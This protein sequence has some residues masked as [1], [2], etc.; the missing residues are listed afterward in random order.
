M[1]G[2]NACP[3][4]G[5]WP[6][7]GAGPGAAG[8]SPA[9]GVSSTSGRATSNCRPRRCQ[10]LPPVTR[11]GGQDQHLRHPDGRRR[12]AGS[13]SAASVAACGGAGQVGADVLEF[14]QL[15][16]Q[17][18]ANPVQRGAGLVEFHLGG[19]VGMLLDPQPVLQH[20][21]LG[22]PD[23]QAAFQ[24]SL[25]LGGD[26]RRNPLD[27]RAQGGH[28]LL[29]SIQQALD[30]V[31]EIQHPGQGSLPDAGASGG[32]TRKAPRSPARPGRVLKWTAWRDPEVCPQ[33][34]PARRAAA[35]RA[36]EASGVMP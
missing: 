10:Q 35:N 2:E 31:G 1:P 29:A 5:P 16:V 33:S 8:R 4:R 12:V 11:G 22:F 23:G 30:L 24:R 14:H 32:A 21:P 20:V 36:V 18:F 27:Q 25:G 7:P 15:A 6:R 19:A 26:I 13:R 34:A 17:A 3:P 28:P 9:S